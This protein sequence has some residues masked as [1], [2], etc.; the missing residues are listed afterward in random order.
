[1]DRGDYYQAKCA[2]QA[3]LLARVQ[4]E[5]LIAR[6]RAETAAVLTKFGLPVADAYHCDDDALTLTPQGGPT[7]GR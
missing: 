3:E 6:A 2:I 4:A 1:M 7:D 5:R